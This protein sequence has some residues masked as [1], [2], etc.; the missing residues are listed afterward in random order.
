M[1]GEVNE[2]EDVHSDHTKSPFHKTL[3]DHGL[4]HVETKHFKNNGAFAEDKTPDT[5]AHTYE[6][7]SKPGKWVAQVT[8]PHDDSRRPHCY[9]KDAKGDCKVHFTPENLDAAITKT[10][11][12]SKKKK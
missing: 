11:P 7:P 1:E 2:V 9:H 5:T 4:V 6:H 10:G 8:M 12:S 3:T